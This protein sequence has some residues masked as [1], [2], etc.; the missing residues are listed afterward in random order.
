MFVTIT[1]LQFGTVG[2][3]LSVIEVNAETTKSEPDDVAREK[4][5]E[6]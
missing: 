6:G 5:E 3:L 2:N 4:K 1:V